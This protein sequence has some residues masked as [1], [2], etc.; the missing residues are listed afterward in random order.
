MPKKKFPKKKGFSEAQKRAFH[1]GFGV[2]LAGE[3]D[4][5]MT[6]RYRETLSPS[7]KN[8]FING[9]QKGDKNAALMS[10]MSPFKRYKRK[11]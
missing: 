9:Y 10:G 3:Y 1:I 11:K 2:G 5:A 7:E 4:T 8:S 6:R